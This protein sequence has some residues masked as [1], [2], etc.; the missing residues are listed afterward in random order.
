MKNNKSA[1]LLM[2]MSMVSMFAQVSK[3]ND[4]DLKSFNNGRYPIPNRRKIK[5]KKRKNK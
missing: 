3:M 2:A 1:A 5:N 4:Y